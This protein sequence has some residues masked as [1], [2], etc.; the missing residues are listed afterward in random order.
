MKPHYLKLALLCLLLGC[1]KDPEN[2]VI[3]D[4][5]ISTMEVKEIFPHS[6]VVLGEIKKIG[7]HNIVEHGFV[8]SK[9]PEP[10]FDDIKIA[11]G[12]I[13]DQGYFQSTFQ[14]L[15]QESE[16]YVRSYMKYNNSI[17]YGNTVSFK[18]LKPN[19]WIEKA[20]YGGGHL[21]GAGN[22]VIDDKWYVGTGLK[23]N[24]VNHFYEYNYRRNTWK[25]ISSLPS[26]PRAHGISF[27]IGEY[28][29][30]GLGERCAGDGFCQTSY[31][32][33]LWRYDPQNDT[34][35][36]MA[37]F[38]GTPRASSTS[39]VV[40]DKAYV[41]GGSSYGDNDLWEYDPS[42]NHWT[43]KADY[44]GGCFARGT[45]FALNNKGYVGFGWTDGT[46]KDLWEYDPSTDTWIQKEDFPGEPRYNAVSFSLMGKG[47]LA[48]GANQSYGVPNYLSDLWTYDPA[49]DEWTKIN[50]SY[51]GKGNVRMIANT[52]NNKIL[53]GLGTNETRSGPYTRFSDIWEYV[54]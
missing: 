2:I 3:E 53:M 10:T 13:K 8:L 38:P 30:V 34:W 45:S 51:P 28:G 40:G 42:T 33:D 14:E 17:E 25:Q 44:P 48:C 4:P 36:K 39:F 35:S 15:D 23:D 50:T 9:Q 31:F 20:N 54:Q 16:Y 49:N 29:Y 5:E 52:I 43:K 41:T 27:A 22:F 24:Y 46:C 47:Y 37:N 12:S 11:L 6:A 32:K 19:S 1:S 21:S 26:D 18:T 7:S